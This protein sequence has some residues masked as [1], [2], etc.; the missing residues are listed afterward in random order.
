MSATWRTVPPGTGSG[1]ARRIY[2]PM[3]STIRPSTGTVIR[4]H[5]SMGWTGF[6]AA[7]SVLLLLLSTAVNA[8]GAEGQELERPGDDYYASAVRDIVTKC[9][10]RCPD[11]VSAVGKIT[12][13]MPGDKNPAPM[14]ALMALEHLPNSS[15]QVFRMFQVNNSTWNC[16]QIIPILDPSTARDR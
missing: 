4:P 14:C 8:V 9:I 6:P 3:A 11:Q 1:G 13:S 7:L 15:E 2:Q 5:R 10:N 12:E 16:R